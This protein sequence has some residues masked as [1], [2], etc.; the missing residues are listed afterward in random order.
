MKVIRADV[1]THKVWEALSPIPTAALEENTW[2]SLCYFPPFLIIEISQKIIYWFLW[3]NDIVNQDLH[4]QIK[5]F[6]KIPD[7]CLKGFPMKFCLGLLGFL[8]FLIKLL[9]MQTCQVYLPGKNNVVF[10]TACFLSQWY[11]CGYP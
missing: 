5:G 2:I 11:P 9:S 10:P 3:F 7:L 4:I 6:I 1:P 8:L